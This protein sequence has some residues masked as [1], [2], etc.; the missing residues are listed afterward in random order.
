MKLKNVFVVSSLLLAAPAFAGC[1]NILDSAPVVTQPFELQV[2]EDSDFLV[3]ALVDEAA[4]SENQTSALILE[5]LIQARDTLFV[6]VFPIEIDLANLDSEQ[7]DGSV[8]Q[9]CS[10][11]F[12]SLLD[13]E[14]LANSHP[15]LNFV[16][17]SSAESSSPNVRTVSYA[18]T[19][20]AYLAGYLAA[21]FSTSK[22]LGTF[23]LLGDAESLSLMNAFAAGA[24]A[25]AAEYDVEVL[26]LGLDSESPAGLLLTDFAVAADAYS[27]VLEVLIEEGSDVIFPAIENQSASIAELLGSLDSSTVLIGLG[28][29]VALTN[30]GL[31]PYILTSV[32]KRVDVTVRQI[33]ADISSGS[34]FDSNAYLGTLANGG[35]GLS[36]YYSFDSGLTEETKVRLATLISEINAGEITPLG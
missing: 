21:A 8:L 24:L 15:D 27:A 34:P 19:E 28:H 20:P 7:L 36:P 17:F 29:D 12:S 23:G 31:A 3:C 11:T 32:E 13:T 14:A 5:G 33:S 22:I 9:N 30:P 1:S 2:P 4:E 35:T 16:L 18:L 25:Y 10:V 26:I 6:E